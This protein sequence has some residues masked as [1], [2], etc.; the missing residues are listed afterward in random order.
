[1]AKKQEKEQQNKPSR[2]KGTGGLRRSF[3]TMTI[4]PIILMGIVFLTAGSFI[5]SRAL[6]SEMKDDLYDVSC[7]VQIYYD[8]VF[9][10]SYNLLHDEAKGALYLKKGGEIISNDSRYLEEVSKQT[11]TEITLFFSDIRMMSTLQYVAGE[12]IIGT[13]ANTRIS[14]PVVN[15]GKISF[16][17]SVEIGKERYCA[18]YVPIYGADGVCTGMIGVA[19]PYSTVQGYVNRLEIINAI[20]ILMTI[21]VVGLWIAAYSRSLSRT[22]G[23]LSDF[24][25]RV[26]EGNLDVELEQSVL[27]RNDEI[28]DIG[29][30]AMN[31]KTQLKSLIEKDPLTNLNNRRSG[32]KKMDQIRNKSEK[33]VQN[34]A[35]AMGDIDFFKK[36]NDNYGHDAGDAVLR[37][38]AKILS[39][40]MAGQGTVIRWGGEEF[41]FLFA[42]SD[43]TNAKT[44]LQAILDTV[45]E[46]CVVYDEQE[47]R[48]TMSYG[49]VDGDLSRSKEEDIN[50]ADALLYYAKEHGRNQVVSTVDVD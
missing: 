44:K 28:S 32:L 19:K 8:R 15:Q 16:F 48:F 20:I 1:M 33:Y 25:S 49:V 18:L 7:T 39:D 21:L 35:V 23:K 26:A 6:Q 40:A 36:V 45:R 31:V 12:D 11:E 42:D 9:P 41:L 14:D 22:I 5:Y 38:T 29:R 27:D 24:L 4:F 3:L 13:V 10:G 34:Y 50:A 47:I 46:T 2:H 17:D 43:M 37:E 30:D